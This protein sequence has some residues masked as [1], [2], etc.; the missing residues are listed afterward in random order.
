V[1][2]RILIRINICF[3]HSKGD[4]RDG[5]NFPKSKA[6]LRE[7]RLFLFPGKQQIARFIGLA[8]YPLSVL[9]GFD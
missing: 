6:A 5:I 3:N 2:A 8:D 9:S 4:P 7:D 1:L